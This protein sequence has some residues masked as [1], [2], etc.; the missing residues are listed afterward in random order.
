M[1]GRSQLKDSR[2]IIILTGIIL[3]GILLGFLGS[4][5]YVG[6]T[7]NFKLFDVINYLKPKISEWNKIVYVPI[8]DQSI[9]QIGRWPWSRNKW[10]SAFKMLKEL[11]ADKIV[12]DVEFID[13]SDVIVDTENYGLLKDSDKLY[14]ASELLQKVIIDPDRQFARAIAKARNV[15]LPCRGI[16][17]LSI[18]P[19]HDRDLNFVTR[20]FFQTLTDPS[21]TNFLPV[22]ADLEVPFTTLAFG[23]KG[24]GF[25]S[26]DRDLDGVLRRM[27]LFRVYKNYLVP[28]LALRALMDEN[29]VD[30]H[31]IVIKPGRYIELSGSNT[32]RIPIDRKG[33]MLV[34]WTQPWTRS[35]TKIPIAKFI[36]YDERRTLLEQSEQLLKQNV[37]TMTSEERAQS[38]QDIA[39]LKE[40]LENIQKSWKE[41]GVY[42][43]ISNKIVIIGSSYSAGTDIGSIP[44]DPSAPQVMVYGNVINTIHMHG[45]MYQVHW[46]QNLLFVLFFALLIPL[47][48]RRINNAV[49][50][51]L[52][53]GSGFVLFLAASYVF[54][55]TLNLYFNY[56]FS[57]IA[58][59]FIYLG[60]VVFKFILYDREKNY[61]K[62]A[63]STYL[64]PDVV[65]QVVENPE[66]LSLGGEER[67][68]TAYFSDVQGFTTISES[69]TPKEL[70]NLLNE[71]LTVMTNIILDE[72]G[73][74][75]KYEGDAVVA[76]YG[77]PVPHEDHAIRACRGMVKMQKALIP[78]RE[79][80]LSEGKPEM[81]VR[82]GINTGRAVVGNMG[83]DQRMDY[84]MMGDTVNLA[85]RLE[86]ANKFY[87]TY[88]MISQFTYAQV[89]HEFLCRELDVLR[90]KGKN[91]PIRV[92][93]V[94]DE[95][96]LASD[97]DRRLVEIYNQAL[98]LY[99]NRQWKEARDLFKV[100]SVEYSDKTSA[101]YAE[102][103]AQFIKESPPEDWNGVF[104]LKSK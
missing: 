27:A 66:F 68:I 84:T 28:H 85:A 1:S 52:L 35:F 5:S 2:R 49:K 33:R 51:V 58:L 59:V 41:N 103:C 16:D 21:L 104:V 19:N 13:R 50:E 70:V 99:Q 65:N 10:V 102:R 17:E 47:L 94:I 101:I 93:Q 34:N 30:P 69:M 89:K 40:E 83:T 91:E 75:D 23:A 82:M 46:W 79:K 55:F 45:F 43:K 18:K 60:F 7:L 98:S 25:T 8:D 87:A 42:E 86:G 63:F 6:K 61:I 95:E 20:R 73:T 71:Y 100:V 38:V 64:S 44:I 48:D 74:V 9:D 77:A 15:Y 81:F 11:G 97:W 22:D 92:Y 39:G 80:W 36:D 29:G 96:H 90:V 88:S 78:L 76:F 31:S 14:T 26:A 56:A 12:L 37:A 53:A 54:S 72:G 3:G 32:V 4:L 24:V 62:S 57:L 67:E